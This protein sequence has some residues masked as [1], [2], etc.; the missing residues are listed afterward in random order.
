MVLSGLSETQ[1]TKDD[2]SSSGNRNPATE[3]V[4][5]IQSSVSLIA[6]AK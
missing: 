1:I 5:L 6:N 2:N 4:L 3:C